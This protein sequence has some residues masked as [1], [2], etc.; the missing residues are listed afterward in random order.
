MCL[1]AIRGKSTIIVEW[2]TG[3]RLVRSLLCLAL[4]IVLSSSAATSRVLLQPPS[5]LALNQ[6]L[7]GG[8]RYQI[9]V[10]LP[11]NY[12]L[13]ALVEQ[14]GIDVI[15]NAYAPDGKLIA[16][17]DR[18][19]GERGPEVLHCVSESSGPHVIE[20]AAAHA[21]ARPGFYSL[22]ISTPRPAQAKDRQLVRAQDALAR[23]EKLR[24]EG[25]AA[26]SI[27]VFKTAVSDYL[28]AEDAAGAAVA[29]LAQGRSH[30]FLNQTQPGLD[31]FRQ[32]QAIF[33]EAGER[34]GEALALSR[35]GGAYLAFDSKQAKECYRQA[36]DLAKATGNQ[37]IE[38][39]VLDGLGYI[40]WV[41][42][43]L[44]TALSHFDQARD[45][46]RALGHSYEEAQTVVQIAGVLNQLGDY[47]RGMEL[48][49]EALRAHRSGGHLRE[50]A[51]A[52]T[53]LADAYL[54]VG[55]PDNAVASLQQ[56]LEITRRGGYQQVEVFTLL[57]LGDLY[58]EL[59][60]AEAALNQFS[61][62]LPLIDAGIT[63]LAPRLQRSLGQTYAALHRHR[64]ALDSFNRA[65]DGYQQSGQ[66]GGLPEV[67]YSAGLVYLAMKQPERALAHL[68]KALAAFQELKDPL[69][70]ARTLVATAR[71]QASQGQ[72]AT[73]AEQSD[74]ALTLLESLRVNLKSYETRA[75]FFATVADAYEQR[76]DILM[77]RH[78]REP[79]NGFD[80]AAFQFSERARA[81]SLLDMLSE[82]QVDLERDA[83]LTLLGRLRELQ[84]SL[85]D[86]AKRRARL[87]SGG[88][89]GTQ[90][91]VDDAR[92]RELTTELEQIRARIRA[93]SPRYAA[94]A[95]PQ[96]LTLAETQLL[97]DAGTTLLEYA[98]GDERSF[99]WAVS[100]DAVTSYVLPKRA[101]IAQAARRVKETVA[102]RRPGASY[103]ARAAELSQM[104]LGPVAATIG[105]KRLVI[106]APEVL[107][108]I[109]FAALPAPLSQSGGAP[110][111][112]AASRATRPL[113]MDHEIINLPSASVLAVL[114]REASKRQPAPK[115]V[116]V[117]ADPVFSADDDRVKR[118]QAALQA[119]GGIV[120]PA[121]PRE[122][123]P[124]T[125]PSVI[126]SAIRSI[127]GGQERTELARLLNTADEAASVLA[128][129]L[130]EVSL[131][132]VDFQASKALAMSRDLGQYRIIHF[133]THG[134]LVDRYPALSGLVFSLI[135]EAG[136]PQDGFLRLHEI[137]N[138]RLNA[139]LV[140]LSAC[141]TGI[142]KAVRG[143]GLIGLARG[144]MNA[145]ASRVV[146]SLWQA[147]DEATAA[148]M[149]RFYR[150]LLRDGLP[151]AAALR[152]AQVD[153]QRKN[154]WRAPF[155]WGAFVLQGDW[156]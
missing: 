86:E 17:A 152:A 34:N 92:L 117:L 27:P 7:R 154:I 19:T 14:Q 39:I 94:L 128:A 100:R 58:L 127:R 125:S 107:Q 74:I 156:Q 81:R 47:Q 134:L 102:T 53:G 29:Y 141:Q 38:S 46:Q 89:A 55:D 150:G 77:L 114:R 35:L 6:E 132:A 93:T 126:E 4:L 13:V 145:G 98:L 148:L 105:S 43:N 146:A 66:F 123:I 69:N 82:A 139:E 10:L 84:Q 5:G 112:R 113:V 37:F 103:A 59:G 140:T 131:K 101:A 110:A 45:M 72:L 64:E 21:N 9:S 50:E 26:A 133:A 153:I 151:P 138:L 1:Q 33:R 30:H 18:H 88:A 106:V 122:D 71:V 108:Y 49:Q 16:R 36:M 78:A 40:Q 137:Y 135:D 144:F 22:T 20:V 25:K 24:D 121:P 28:A 70:T 149:K 63:S 142:G 44:S 99:L 76:I 96:A 60:Q 11:A 12:Y 95:Q 120:P 109:P 79:A 2:R 42:G 48:Y 75:S 68:G 61:R 87:T 52:L 15:V 57:K 115:A 85:N 83:D 41:A 119:A 62:A 155:Y 129:A 136:R 31:C 124:A 116:A 8:G 51:N 67:Y 32:A 73:A 54:F 23:G 91:V 97:L 3:R 118:S 111:G 147:D 104:L 143:E 80:R 56:A 90:D 65:L 130:P